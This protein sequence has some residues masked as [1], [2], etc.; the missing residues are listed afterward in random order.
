MIRRPP[1]STLSSSSAASD[2]YK[3]Q[4]PPLMT[5]FQPFGLDYPRPHP[6]YTGTLR[7]ASS[8]VSSASHWD[9]PMADD[10]PWKKFQ[11]P[12]GSTLP[13]RGDLSLI[14]ISEPTR[15]LSIS[16]AVFCLK[17]KKNKK[18]KTKCQHNIKTTKS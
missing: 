11:G 1:R 16:Y 2:V 12:I 17:K 13:S 18:R 6:P 3:R 5:S 14:H 15:L 8:S 10:E 9:D 4:P 7:H